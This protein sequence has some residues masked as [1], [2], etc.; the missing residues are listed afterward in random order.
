MYRILVYNID[1]ETGFSF[2]GYVTHNDG[3]ESDGDYENYTYV[4]KSKF[5]DDYFYTISNKYIKVSEIEDT[6]TWTAEPRIQGSFVVNNGR[7]Y[8]VANFAASAFFSS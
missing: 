8:C 5:I 3:S 4:Y 2:N 7:K 6:E 1:L